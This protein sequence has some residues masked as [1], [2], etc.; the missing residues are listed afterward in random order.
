MKALIV[1]D[2][3][4]KYAA[5]KRAVAKWND[6]IFIHASTLANAKKM[7]EET[8]KAD[9]HFDLIVTDMSYPEQSGGDIN[10]HA[11]FLLIEWI[12]SLGLHIPV[13]ICS[14]EKFQADF[15]HHVIGSVRY[16]K[17]T[18]MDREFQTLLHTL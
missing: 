12:S 15:S 11:G 4:F 9:G 14:S 6:F 7:I 5:V 3:I 17:K 16:S 8:Y 2:N 1:E 10:P 13:I 18:D